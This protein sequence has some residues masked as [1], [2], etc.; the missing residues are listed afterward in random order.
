VH[1]CGQP[2][3]CFRMLVQI[4]LS[5]LSLEGGAEKTI[6]HGIRYFP[7]FPFHPTSR[8]KS[9]SCVHIHWTLKNLYGK[10]KNYL[11]LSQVATYRCP[12]WEEHGYFL[13]LVFKC[14]TSPRV[15]TA[16]RWLAVDVLG[17]MREPTG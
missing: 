16:Y 13:A 14:I 8:R 5:S 1:M 2:T 7:R 10:F 9:C 6:M 11:V 4:V 3:S 12:D 15:V 17:H